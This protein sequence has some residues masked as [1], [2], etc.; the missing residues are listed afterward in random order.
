MKLLQNFRK[1]I[2]SFA[3]NIKLGL[4][5]E[6]ILWRNR[7]YLK[8]GDSI[9]IHTTR[10]LIRQSTMPKKIKTRYDAEL[11]ILFG[12]HLDAGESWIEFRDMLINK[13][14]LENRKFNQKETNQMWQK[15]KKDQEGY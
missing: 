2:T 13:Q 5:A 15:W 4:Q 7:N 12:R 1:R 9:P 14:K 10:K 8:T 6:K 11:T 3:T